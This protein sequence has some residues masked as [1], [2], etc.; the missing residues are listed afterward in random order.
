MV[1]VFRLYQYIKYVRVPAFQMATCHNVVTVTY[2]LT[3][4]NINAAY[5][6]PKCSACE[7]H[8]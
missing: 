3:L 7:T 1:L 6:Q 5:A 4:N 2:P 8:F